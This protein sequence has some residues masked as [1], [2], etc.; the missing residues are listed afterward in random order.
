VKA[1]EKLNKISI[2]IGYPDKWKD[3]SHQI[4][5]LLREYF[6][7]MKKFFSM[8]FP[9]ISINLSQLIKQNGTCHHKQ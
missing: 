1:I 5:A 3:Y 2:K 7:N 6:E 4:K 9:K 8:E